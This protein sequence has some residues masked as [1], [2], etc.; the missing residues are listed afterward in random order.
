L[1]D[2]LLATRAW[3]LGATMHFDPSV[4]AYYRQH[5]GNMTRVV[6]PF[7]E[8]QIARDTERVMRHYELISA[9]T[10]PRYIPERLAELSA[11][12][13][14]LE[15]FVRRVIRSKAALDEYRRAVNRLSIPPLWWSS[16]A[17]PEL[18]HMWSQ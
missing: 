14:E 16:V 13:A 15:Q 18:R 4:R 8:A 17:H 11:V 6:G 10:D 9:H 3:L 5:G 12:R 7:A 1:V 2:W